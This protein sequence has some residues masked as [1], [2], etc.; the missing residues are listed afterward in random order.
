M[1]SSSITLRFAFIILLVLSLLGLAGYFLLNNIYQLQLRN[2]ANTVADNVSSFGKWVA[3]YGRVWVDKNSEQSFLGSKILVPLPA[4]QDAIAQSSEIRSH[5]FTMYS[6]NPALAQREFSEVVADSESP[7]KFRLT[8]DNF[9]N[10]VNKPDTFELKAISQIKQS[11]AGYF[12]QFNPEQGEYR[13]ARAV[14]HKASCIACHGDPK[15]A[16][17]DVISRYGDKRGFGFKEGDLAGVISVTLPMSTFAQAALP[18][19]GWKEIALVLAA[20]LI[21]ILFLHYAVLRPLKLLTQQADAASMGDAPDIDLEHVKQNT[22]NEVERLGL[23]IA[24]LNTSTRM[25]I[26]QMKTT[27]NK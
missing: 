9:M 3:G 26:S 16:P 8:S 2:Q 15:A 24:R 22:R 21:A 13:F 23:A 5:S 1:H 27:R 12:E 18:F 19:L 4:A 11:G 17:A 25:A 14:E 7:A 6:K 20:F 10:P